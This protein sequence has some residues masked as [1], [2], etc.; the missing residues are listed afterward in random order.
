[1]KAN[2]KKKKRPTLTICAILA[3]IVSIATYV[4]LLLH[5]VYNVI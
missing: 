4:I 3:V 1:M 5:N 2:N